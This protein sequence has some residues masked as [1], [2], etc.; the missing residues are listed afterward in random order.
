MTGPIEVF[1]VTEA[2]DWGHFAGVLAECSKQNVTQSSTA[3][4]QADNGFQ[5]LVDGRPLLAERWIR[6]GS[7][8]WRLDKY[9]DGREKQMDYVR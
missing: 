9:L 7:C 5:Y 2:T 4:R 3:G 1:D 8:R 6:H